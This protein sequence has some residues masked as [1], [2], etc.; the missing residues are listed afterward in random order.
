MSTI[1][2]PCG[3]LIGKDLPPSL[4]KAQERERVEENLASSFHQ[5]GDCPK[6]ITQVKLLTNFT[7]P[8]PHP[9]HA[10]KDYLDKERR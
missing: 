10:T 5:V 4:I 1:K 3:F 7:T 8:L 6:E 2:D 9:L